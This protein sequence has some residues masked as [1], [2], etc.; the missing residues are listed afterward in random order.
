MS[1]RMVVPAFVLTAL[2]SSW[3]ST[4]VAGQAMGIREVSAS[5]DLPMLLAALTQVFLALHMPLRVPVRRVPRA[6]MEV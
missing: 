1:A 5:A 4:L 2:C 6:L 3:A